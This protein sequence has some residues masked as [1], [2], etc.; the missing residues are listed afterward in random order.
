MSSSFAPLDALNKVVA[1]GDAG[2]SRP[3]TKRPGLPIDAVDEQDR[4]PRLPH[5]E[6]ISLSH[7]VRTLQV[8]N[9]KLI[10]AVKEDVSD[11]LDLLSKGSDVSRFFTEFTLLTLRKSN[12]KFVCDRN[13]LYL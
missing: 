11:S 3:V 13:Q 9:I 12:M 7:P 8:G 6:T 5:F 2:P 10:T 4:I 1:H